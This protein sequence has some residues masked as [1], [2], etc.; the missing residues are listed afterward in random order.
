VLAEEKCHV[1][2]LNAIFLL[3][4]LVEEQQG[5]CLLNIVDFSYDEE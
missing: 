1:E 4:A 2:K 3:E 5:K